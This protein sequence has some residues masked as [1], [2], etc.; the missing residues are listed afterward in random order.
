MREQAGYSLSM[1]KLPFACD[2]DDLPKLGAS[3]FHVSKLI[4]T[5]LIEHSLPNNQKTQQ[6]K[7]PTTQQPNNP[8]IV[9]RD[10]YLPILRP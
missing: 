7:T 1:G 9:C 10:T 6:P 8:V 5:H 2:R 3:D 4:R